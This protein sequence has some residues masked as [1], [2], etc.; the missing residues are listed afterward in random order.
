MSWLRPLTGIGYL[1]QITG[2]IIFHL[3]SLDWIRTSDGAGPSEL[4]NVF[5]WLIIALL[6]SLP[7]VVLYPLGRLF[8]KRTRMPLAV[9]VP[10]LW[11]TYEYL[12]WY[13]G[14][15]I[16][17]IP[18]PWLQLGSTQIDVLWL[19][20]IADLGGVWLV[21]FLIAA[22][23]GALVDLMRLF[24]H[25]SRI[26]YR[27]RFLWGSSAFLAIWVAVASYGYWRLGQP[28]PRTGPTLCLMPGFKTPP[29]IDDA[30]NGLPLAEFAS[31][32]W[33][34]SKIREADA[35][36]WTENAAGE[37]SPS[38]IQKLEYEARE[39]GAVQF[40]GCT[41][42]DLSQ[43]R[44]RRFNSVLVGTP[45]EGAA[46][47]YDKMAIVPWREFTPWTGRLFGL[48]SGAYEKGQNATVYQVSRSAGPLKGVAPLICYDICFPSV[49][50][51]FME[52]RNPRPPLEVYCVAS[53]ERFDSTMTL[54]SL[55]LTQA[56]WR[57]IEMRRPIVRN[58]DMGYSGSID[59]CGRVLAIEADA[60]LSEPTLVGPLPVD[61][62][63]SLYSRWGDW[64]AITTSAVTAALF[65]WS[66]RCS[67]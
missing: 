66:L 54:Q 43:G 23:N 41:R 34:N 28:L 2:I 39:T 56:R 63:Q 44:T 9:I 15:I 31:G 40:I 21:T 38:T 58:V 51:R 27:S 19:A 20:Q 16:S 1:S 48:P 17:E 10:C 5:R 32:F 60:V 67:A 24:L 53:S 36:L 4:G 45:R 64:I 6:A 35:L 22:A 12:R 57:A 37:I 52:T 8:V 55:T 59:S 42:R 46:G 11:T 7:W 14:V 33:N 25:E 13:A 62:R 61:R 26:A 50:R 65:V 29:G 47:Y 49:L 30:R 3:I 18:F